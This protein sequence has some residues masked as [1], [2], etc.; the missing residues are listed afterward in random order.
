M[1]AGDFP[2]FFDAGKFPAQAVR[3]RGLNIFQSNECCAVGF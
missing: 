1:K 3:K 2:A